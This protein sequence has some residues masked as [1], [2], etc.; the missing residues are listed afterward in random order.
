MDIFAS[1]RFRLT[2]QSKSCVARRASISVA[3]CVPT[4]TVN[5]V[6]G[7]TSDSIHGY[8]YSVYCGLSFFKNS[9]VTRII[10]C[11]GIFVYRYHSN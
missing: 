2:Q 6:R 9:E 1:R 5:L 4:A 7:C 10:L 8:L 11:F 3:K